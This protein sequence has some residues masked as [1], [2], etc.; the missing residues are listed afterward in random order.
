MLDELMCNVLRVIFLIFHTK[1]SRSFT[2]D[3][4]WDYLFAISMDIY[5]ELS[6][7]P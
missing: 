3:S 2:I 6:E 7:Y 1:N 5:H 4:Y